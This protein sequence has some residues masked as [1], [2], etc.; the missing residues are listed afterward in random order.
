MSYSDIVFCSLTVLVGSTLQ[1]SIGF[2]MGLFASPI[3]IL[4]DERFVPAPILLSTW[5]LTTFLILRERHAVDVRGLRWA[6]V[7]RAVGTVVAGTMLTL[8]PR[9]RM[10]LVFGFLVLLGVAM[11]LSGLRFRPRRSVLLGA[12][13]MSAVMGTI[14][15]IGGPPMALVY[16][17]AQGARLRATM[18]SFFWVGTVMSLAVLRVVGRFG[19]EEVQLTLVLLPGVLLGLLASRWTAAVVD[20]GHT[21]AV[22][23]TVAAAAGLAVIIRQLG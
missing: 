19:E 4:I 9:E 17:D 21:R 23:L 6:V 20:R 5:V 11:S 7:G 1:G 15:S 18:S 3:L 8:L 22:V 14:A 13:A 2:G 10:P 16:Q 12:G